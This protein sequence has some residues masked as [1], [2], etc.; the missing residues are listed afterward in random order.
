MPTQEKTNMILQELVRR[1]NSNMRRLREI[2]AKFQNIESR[3]IAI[4]NTSISKIGKINDKLS[5]MEKSIVDLENNISRMQITFE[6]VTRRLETFARKNDIKEL[7]KM[8]D[9][10]SPIKN[11]YVTKNFLEKEL[12][13]NK[14]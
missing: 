5:V 1:T 8:F 10:L 13:G 12:R 4:E 9:L 7:E 3:V 11:Q 14:A 6:R 2:E